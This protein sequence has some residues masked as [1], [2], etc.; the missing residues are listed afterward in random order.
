MNRIYIIGSMSQIA[1]IEAVA[2]RLRK[3]K[4]DVRVPQPITTCL[5]E[6]VD[7]CL[8]NIQWCDQVLVIRKLDGTIGESVTHEICFAEYLHKE[9]IFD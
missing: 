1:E 3:E 9:I 2:N 7:E 5:K 6:S 4:N 8:D